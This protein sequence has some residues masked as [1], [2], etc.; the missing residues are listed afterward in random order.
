MVSYTLFDF[1]WV[2]FL[3]VLLPFG[4][5]VL[6]LINLPII[7]GGI[8]GYGLGLLLLPFQILYSAFFD[9]PK[10]NSSSSNHGTSQSDQTKYTENDEKQEQNDSSRDLYSLLGVSTTA[11]KDEIR[12]AFKAKMMMNHPDKLASLD[13]E[14]QRIATERTVAIKDAYERL[15]AHAN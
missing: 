7:I 14:L 3:K 8:L 10:S 9:K 4:L 12:A 6:F 15:T 1:L 13:P 11:T 5:L 2:F